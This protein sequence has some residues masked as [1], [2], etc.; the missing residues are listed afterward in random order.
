MVSANAGVRGISVYYPGQDIRIANGV[1]AD[2][3]AFQVGAH[4]RFVIVGLGKVE[5]FAFEIDWAEATRQ[6]LPRA[7]QQVHVAAQQ[8]AEQFDELWTTR[9]GHGRKCT[10]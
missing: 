8:A 7:L 5:R 9:L 2:K 1:E 3:Q 6:Q 4:I 10:V